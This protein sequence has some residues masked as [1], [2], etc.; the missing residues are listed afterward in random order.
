M[1][2]CKLCSGPV[3]PTLEGPPDKE[4]AIAVQLLYR[5]CRKCGLTF[6]DPVES[7]LIPTFY[8]A[9]T[10]HVEDVPETLRQ[11]KA[12]RRP[13]GMIYLRTPNGV[14]LLSGAFGRNWRGW[15]TPRHLNILTKA[16]LTLAAEASDMDIRMIGTS[17][18]MRAG[19]F[20]GS[21]ANLIPWQLP[22]RAAVLLVHVPMAWALQFGRAIRPDSGEEFVAV[23]G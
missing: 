18:D 22:R 17:N 7:D 8:S 21:M 6:S 13:G 16:A 10:A 1:L 19:M 11:L 23:L 15:E 4:S 20:V 2:G 14:S 5:R 12:Q 9:Y 3:V